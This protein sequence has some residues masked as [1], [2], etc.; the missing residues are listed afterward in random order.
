MASRFLASGKLALAV[1]IAVSAIAIPH[2]AGRAQAPSLP[3]RS[4]TL[5]VVTVEFRPD[6]TFVAEAS[7]EGMGAL[8]A[9][10]QW[11]AEGDIVELVAW[12]S[13]AFPLLGPRD[14][15]EV[16]GRYRH[17]VESGHVRFERVTDDCEA[18]LTLFNGTRW[19][20][21]GTAEV[22]ERRIIRTL[23]KPRPPLP[24]ATD[25]LGSWPSFRGPQ[26]NGVADG[27]QLPDRWSGET[28]EHVLWKTPIPGLSHSSPIVWGDRLFVTSA[29][30]GRGVATLQPGRF[31]GDAAAS[32]DRSRQRWMLYGLDRR[33]GKI[34]WER[35]AHEGEPI[36]KRHI[37][38]T[39]ASATPATDGRVVVSWFGSHGVH[40]YTVNGDF[41][42]KADLGRVNVGALGLPGMEW[43]PASSPIIWND[44][45][46]LQVD[47]QTDSFV[48]ALALETGEQ[49]WKI[50]RDEGP[51]WSTPTVVVTATGATLVAGGAY[52][53]RGYDLRTGGERWRLRSGTM[54][55][56]IPTSVAADGLVV[57]AS[58]NLGPKRP[59]FVIRRTVPQLD[60]AWLT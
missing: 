10:A 7:F 14:G 32:E 29:I 4:L 27:Q 49:V 45:V 1:A 12:N 35:T 46:I 57:V 19:R 22:F 50:E 11:K 43:G 31:P 6:G 58:S 8:R 18:R 25:P 30:S 59:L 9:S 23:A 21:T 41:L 24:R 28:G 3:F 37:R 48:V 36:D 2:T 44:L 55:G 47:T 5:G 51:S 56:P 54:A 26:A 34:L 39:Y 40:A 17:A 20:P 42:W 15:C 33:T 16:P 53:I 38:S 13:E 60:R 52:Y